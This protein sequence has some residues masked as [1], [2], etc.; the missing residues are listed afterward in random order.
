MSGGERT[1]VPPDEALRGL[2]DFWFRL[3][4]VGFV[5]LLLGVVSLVWFGVRAGMDPLLGYGA[6]G[7]AVVVAVLALS[8]L[9]GVRR[10]A[11]R[12]ILD[13]LRGLG[14]SVSVGGR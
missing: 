11:P 1:P 6:L 4:C 5:S 12:R 7:V 10:R 8:W 2:A 14:L 9:D 13:F 3:V